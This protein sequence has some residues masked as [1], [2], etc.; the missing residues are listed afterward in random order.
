MTTEES[1]PL[2]V[3]LVEDNPNDARLIQTY[4]RTTDS[5]LL[6]DDVD[7]VH[8]ETLDDGIDYLAEEAVDILLLDLGLKKTKGTETFDRVRSH[9][10]DIPVIVLTGL[11][12]QEAAVDLLQDGA[13]DY[14]TKNSLGADR[15]QKSIRYALERKERERELA[16]ANERL[17]RQ[18]AQLEFF[19]SILRHD[20]L[21]GMTVIKMRAEGLAA[22]LSGEQAQDAEAIVQWSENLSD[23]ATRVRKVSTAAMESPEYDLVDLSTIVTEQVERVASAH[24][25]VR[26]E[27][28][29][30]PDVQAR[31]DDLLSNVVG[32]LLTN[33]VEHNDT[34][35]LRVTVTVTDSDPVTLVIEDDGVGVP[36]DRKEAIF[37]REETDAPT[38]AGTGFGLFFV[39]TMV[40]E[41]GGDVRVEDGAD[42]GARFVVELPATEDDP[43]A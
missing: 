37:R 3:L 11:Q 2:Q 1:D 7:L 22:A 17:E 14:L 16:A 39:D 40:T 41:Y 21:N 27:P 43:T 32:N 34:T 31:G 30:P 19:S 18:S 29:V 24:E 12:D 42:G 25:S 5:L 15:L 10:E 28:D 20:L 6:P 36:D 33:A 23:I 35:D 38:N 9:A 8:E 4:L 26:F 13:Q